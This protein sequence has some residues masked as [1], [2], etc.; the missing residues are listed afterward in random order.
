MRATLQHPDNP[1]KV[2]RYGWDRAL[3]WWVEVR[4]EG[5]LPVEYDALTVG[6]MTSVARLLAILVE[7]GFFT[8]DD[9]H[10]AQQWLVEVDEVD[11]VEDPGAQ[12]AAEVLVTLR[13]VGH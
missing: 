8:E 11:E 1:K 12:R 3:S 10:E 2:A 4:Q 9:L 5:R 6:E 7:H 13:H